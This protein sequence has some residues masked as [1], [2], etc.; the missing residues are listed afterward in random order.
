[1]SDFRAR[2]PRPI[3]AFDF[4][5]SFC[6]SR[7]P[8]IRSPRIFVDVRFPRLVDVRFP[9]LV[10]WMSVFRW[11]M[12][13]FRCPRSGAFSAYFCR[14]SPQWNCSRKGRCKLSLGWIP[15]ACCSVK[16]PSFN[17]EFGSAHL[18]LLFFY[19][20]FS[21]VCEVCR[22]TRDF[23]RCIRKGPAR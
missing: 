10:L 15:P 9:V 18:L 12:S 20:V 11:W 16:T 5:S 17:A 1:M 23:Q 13:V 21:C 8:R 14:S 2:F 6:G 4:R 22:L 19:A 7:S 3:S